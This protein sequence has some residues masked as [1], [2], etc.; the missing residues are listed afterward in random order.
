MSGAVLVCCWNCVPC[1]DAGCGISCVSFGN[2]TQPAVGPGM[3]SSSQWGT[4]SSGHSMDILILEQDQ[5]R[6]AE[7]GPWAASENAV[8]NSYSYW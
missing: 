4:W 2:G 5:P 8:W 7:R 1:A 3:G 6:A